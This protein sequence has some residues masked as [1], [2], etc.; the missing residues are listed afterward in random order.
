VASLALMV[1]PIRGHTKP[2]HTTCEREVLILFYPHAFSYAYG[3]SR[4]WVE[5][6]L[7]I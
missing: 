3:P 5:S 2:Y 6:I 7:Q 1:E 4:E